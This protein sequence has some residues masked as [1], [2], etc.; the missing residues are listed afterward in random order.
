MLDQT[1]VKSRQPLQC[2]TTPRRWAAA[3][4]SCYHSA[5]G[6]LLA[7]VHHAAGNIWCTPCNHC[8]PLTLHATLCSRLHRSSLL[9]AGQARPALTRRPRLLLLLQVVDQPQLHKLLDA[10][11]SLVSRADQV[12]SHK[13]ALANCCK[14]AR[15]LLAGDKSTMLARMSGGDWGGGRAWAGG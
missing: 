1:A 11:S 2:A 15:A 10:G 6:G 8:E 5:W 3:A 7:R 13:D 12:V 14:L 4:D 9:A